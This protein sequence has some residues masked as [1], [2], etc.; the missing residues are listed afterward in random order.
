M[1]SPGFVAD[2]EE[3]YLQETHSDVSLSIID[4]AAAPDDARMA[5]RLTGHAMV[6]VVF[7]SYCKSKVIKLHF[8][9]VHSQ[10][11]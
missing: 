5:R 3:Y 6:L 8:N 7:S 9:E 11:K 2:F 10:M 4:D 1:S